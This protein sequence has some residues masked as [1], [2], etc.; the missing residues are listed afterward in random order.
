VCHFNRQGQQKIDPLNME[1]QATGG[2][3]MVSEQ[4]RL[5]PLDA[6]DGLGHIAQV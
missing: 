1:G 6:G 4:E 5:T 2:A 3:V